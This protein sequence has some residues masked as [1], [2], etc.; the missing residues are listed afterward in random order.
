MKSDT[1]CEDTFLFKGTIKGS[2]VSMKN[3]RRV[4][5]VHGRT[6]VVKKEKALAWEDLACLQIKRAK[7]PY[8]YEVALI[9]NFYYD[10]KR[11]DLDENLLKDMIQVK[12]KDKPCL[13]IILDDNQIKAHDTAW[14]LD[15]QNPRVEFTLMDLST[16]KALRKERYP[17]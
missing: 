7:V 13:G 5:R 1:R 17:K 9:A 14:Y 12:R 6:I 4:F 11:A 10:Q 3:S 15:K 2:Y 16:Y 8:E